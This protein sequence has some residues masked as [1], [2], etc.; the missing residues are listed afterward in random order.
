MSCNI[1]KKPPSLAAPLY[2]WNLEPVPARDA[3][4]PILVSV[5]ILHIWA[6]TRTISDAPIPSSIL[7]LS[8][9]RR[10]PSD[11]EREH[12]TSFTGLSGSW[13]VGYDLSCLAWKTDSLL[14]MQPVFLTNQKA[15]QQV[16][17]HQLVSLLVRKP[18][19]LIVMKQ[20]K[21]VFVP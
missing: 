6:S 11:Q 9:S 1:K 8:V 21:L 13:A 16:M 14:A 17:T 18:G 12:G 3:Q 5:P 15:R 2:F 7:E 20:I 19:L 10:S 4:I